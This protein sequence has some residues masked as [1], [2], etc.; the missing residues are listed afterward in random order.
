MEINTRR[1]FF[2]RDGRSHG[3]RAETLGSADS[4]CRRARPGVLR[5]G[6]GKRLQGSWRSSANI[7][8]AKITLKAIAGAQPLL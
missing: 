1:D 7:F 6:M 3:R 8:S 4:S 5:F 2:S